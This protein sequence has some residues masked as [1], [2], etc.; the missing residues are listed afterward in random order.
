MGD[1]NVNKY[2]PAL[3]LSK[4]FAAVDPPSLLFD[5]PSLFDISQA[6]PLPAAQGLV[7]ASEQ[8]CPVCGP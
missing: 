1:N 2:F 8:G 7:T 3:L 5:S 6:S 4:F